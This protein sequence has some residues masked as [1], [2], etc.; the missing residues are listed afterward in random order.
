MNGLIPL[1][2]LLNI[3]LDKNIYLKNRILLLHCRLVVGW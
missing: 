1:I 3:S 2:V